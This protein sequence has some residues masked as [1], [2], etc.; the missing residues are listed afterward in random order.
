VRNVTISLCRLAA[1]LA[2]GLGVGAAAA[3]ES[4]ELVFGGGPGYFIQD[5]RGDIPR[6]DTPELTWGVG[7]DL[8]VKRIGVAYG[9]TV[10]PS[11]V[12]KDPRSPFDPVPMSTAYHHDF[13]VRWF[14]LVRPPAAFS[15]GGCLDVTGIYTFPTPYHEVS[16]RYGS[17]Q[18]GCYVGCDLR[19]HERVRMAL[20]FGFT[21]RVKPTRRTGTA[22]QTRYVLSDT[23]ASQ[24]NAS[25]WL[26]DFL[27][28]GVRTSLYVDGPGEPKDNEKFVE[29]GDPPAVCWAVF[30]GPA[31]NFS[32]F[33]SYF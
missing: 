2:S 18:P 4:A 33:G 29:V 24:L 26:W 16:R 23:W 31:L 25:Y 9:L 17:F 3:P 12:Y 19:P 7:L 6:D 8:R 21:R 14:F 30:V 15:V 1:L 28:V 22:V 11:Y 27:G 20:E 5:V 32:A 13:Y 10:E